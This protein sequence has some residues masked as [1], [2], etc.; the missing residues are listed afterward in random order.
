MLSICLAFGDFFDGIAHN[1]QPT[2]DLTATA[3]QL[4]VAVT[5]SRK[6]VFRF[7]SL[8]HDHR[9]RATPALALYLYFV[10]GA[11]W[12]IAIA[13]AMGFHISQWELV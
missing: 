9:P 13:I 11:G 5:D 3:P 10:L 6:L 12:A 8:A 7:K 1:A 2:A 4:A